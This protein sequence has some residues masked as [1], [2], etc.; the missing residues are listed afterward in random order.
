MSDALKGKKTALAAVLVALYGAAKV[1][2]P[3]KTPNLPEGWEEG[4]LAV[5]FLGLRLVT[6]GPHTLTPN[7]PQPPPEKP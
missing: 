4:V 1:F 6:N 5:L 2:W 7:T 3:A